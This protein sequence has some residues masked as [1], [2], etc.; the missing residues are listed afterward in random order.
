MI[1]TLIVALHL[2]TGS[3]DSFERFIY[4]LSPAQSTPGIS[5]DTSAAPDLA[6]WAEQ[7]RSLAREWYPHICELLSTRDYRSPKSLKFVFRMNQDAPAYCAGDEISFSVDWVRKHPDDFGMVIHEL[8]H[9]VQAYPA[10]KYD[11]GWLTEGIAD[12]IRWWR[13]EPETPRPKINFA[14]ASYRDAYRT[15]AYFLAWVAQKYD[16]RLVPQLDAAMRK[17]E[18]PE[19]VFK[20]LTGK[21][22]TDLWNE[23]KNELSE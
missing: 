7:A 2:T 6:P 15:T 5:I 18:D 14:K 8:T 17:A 21:S 9:V 4:P 1:P 19:P 23:F 20:S 3:A 12:Y 11:A 22:A 13:Y 10:N 16:R